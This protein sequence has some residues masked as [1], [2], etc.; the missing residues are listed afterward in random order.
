[1]LNSVTYS[2]NHCLKGQESYEPFYW[3][4]KI[5]I[6]SSNSCFVFQ[7]KVNDMQNH[8]GEYMTDL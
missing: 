8:E 2:L 5:N 6:I 1:M 7:T 4:L 3:S